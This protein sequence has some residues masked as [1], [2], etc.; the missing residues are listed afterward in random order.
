MILSTSIVLSGGGGE[1]GGRDK[2]TTHTKT[3]QGGKQ[4][5]ISSS[6]S[7]PPHFFLGE[8]SLLGPV[9]FWK[10]K[11]RFKFE[12]PAQTTN[13]WYERK[14]KSF[15]LLSLSFN[16]QRE[17]ERK[18]RRNDV[19]LHKENNKIKK[20]RL[21]FY[22]RLISSGLKSALHRSS[23]I[24]CKR[25]WFGK[26]K[27]K[28]CELFLLLFPTDHAGGIATIEQDEKIWLYYK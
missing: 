28:N 21:S 2:Y 26:V 13:D 20:R 5:A 10:S 16:Q 25:P 6:N 12:F 19:N 18:R 3:F 24:I 11:K 8:I 23:S 4:L 22:D 17:R 7:F 9:A 1:R 27:K 15:L 14:L